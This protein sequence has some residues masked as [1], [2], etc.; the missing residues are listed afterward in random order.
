MSSKKLKIM[1][2]ED[3]KSVRESHTWF[4]EDLGNE[5]IFGEVPF[6]CD[7][8]KG[9]SCTRN[10]PCADVLIIDHHLPGMKGLEFLADLKTKGCK[11]PFSNVLLISGDTTSIDMDKAKEIGVTVVQKPIEIE[12]LEAWL[13]NI[14]RP[15]DRQLNSIYLKSNKSDPN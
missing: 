14:K 3:E 11:R 9:Y 6:S 15:D 2:V 10:A 7:V 12:F 5:V 8:W 1:I 4:F 13:K